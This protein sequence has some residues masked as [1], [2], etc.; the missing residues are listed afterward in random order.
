[1]PGFIQVLTIAQEVLKRLQA[2]GG[3]PIT[4]GVR[5]SV[6]GEAD[7]LGASTGRRGSFVPSDVALLPEVEPLGAVMAP[8]A[9]F[10]L[11][12]KLWA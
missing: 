7:A 3:D 4:A 12:I 6:K 8:A 2:S 5:D 9:F 1:M 10:S 11:S